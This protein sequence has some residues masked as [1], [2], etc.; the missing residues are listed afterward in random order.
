MDPLSARGHF[1]FLNMPLELTKSRLRKRLRF[2]MKTGAQ[3]LSANPHAHTHTHTRTHDVSM[4]QRLGT[5]AGVDRLSTSS[6][7]FA[8]KRS[9]GRAGS[10]KSRPVTLKSVYANCVQA[11]LPR[12]KVFSVALL[13][14]QTPSSVAT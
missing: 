14:G 12:V 4:G 7:L 11:S 3:S 9:V 2:T 8:V 10:F 1:L 13:A 6:A 5:C